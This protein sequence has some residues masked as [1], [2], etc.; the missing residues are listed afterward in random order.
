MSEPITKKLIGMT[1]TAWTIADESAANANCNR[2]EW[3]EWITLC[4]SHGKVEADRLFN[5]RRKRGERGE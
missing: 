1:A 4:Q 2:S 3:I 5:N